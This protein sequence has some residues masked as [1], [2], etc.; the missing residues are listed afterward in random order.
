MSIM[1]HDELPVFYDKNGK[2]WLRIRIFTVVMAIGLLTLTWYVLPKLLAFRS[3]ST[4]PHAPQAVTK[5]DDVVTAINDTNITVVGSGPFIRIA[6]VV[7]NN[8]QSSLVDPFTNAPLGRLNPDEEI[9]N[10]A[11]SY[12]MQRYGAEQHKRIFLTFDDGPDGRYSPQ[13][14]D[15]LAKHTVTASFFV[16]GENAVKYSDV[17]RRMVREGH[18]IGGHTFNHIDF[19]AVSKFRGQQEI[20]QTTRIIEAITGVTPGY[21]RP[22]Y[23]GGS[24]ESYRNKVQGITTAQAMGYVNVSYDYDTNDWQHSSQNPIRTLPDFTTNKDLTILMH[25]GGGN[26]TETVQYLERFIIAAKANGYTFGTVRELTSVG[27]SYYLVSANKSRASVA[28][29]TIAQS[30]L[31]WPRKIIMALFIITVL[32]IVSVSLLNIALAIGYNIRIKRRLRF[33]PQHYMPSVTVII[34]AYNEGAVLHKTVA[35]LLASSYKKLKIVLV[36]DGSQDDTW[37]I[38]QKLEQQFPTVRALHQSNTGKAGA[39]NYALRHVRS[40]IVICVDADTIFPAFTIKNLVRHFHDPTVGAV[41]GVV[42]VGNVRGIIT[43]WQALEY[44]VS[45]TLERNAQALLGSIMIVP[46]AC[47]AWRRSSVQAV[48]G[49]SH[50]TLAEDCDLTLKLQRAHY[51]IIQ[52]NQAI[53]YTEAPETIHNLVKQRFR[54]TFGIMQVLWANRDM[55]YRPRYKWL[56]MYSIPASLTAILMPLVFWPV[57]IMLTIENI[58]AGNYR[59][60]VMYSILSLMLQ[61]FFAI[62]ALIFSRERL[63]LL[64]ALP[65]ARFVFAPI[66]AYILS[67]TILIGLQGRMVGWSKLVRT[68]TVAYEAIHK[69]GAPQLPKA[70]T[71]PVF[72]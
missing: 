62:I 63:S 38:M 4:V 20:N 40:Q 69:Q 60:I 7:H 45:I 31:I 1:L 10:E 44:T 68:N 30:L 3:V 59:I 54:W 72:R 16:V 9:L 35:S 65:F 15:T 2:R 53:G 67:K 19:D 58:A 71:H 47:G 25:D 61:V 11:N 50:R 70:A 17:L 51:R 27:K 56:G 48:G 42:K 12:V 18:M 46:G 23:M 43:R 5:V 28:A 22:P 14:L 37:L 64:L 13:I 8:L 55:I 49:F 24:D 33:Y 52:D 29:S 26:R 66:R 36:D 57:L 21:F 32:A 39:L 41:A 34:P 6:K